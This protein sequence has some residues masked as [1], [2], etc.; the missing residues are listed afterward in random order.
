[1]RITGIIFLLA[2]AF[3]G[4]ASAGEL[5]VLSLPE[6]TSAVALSV[7]NNGENDL[8]RVTLAVNRENLPAWLSVLE[9]PQT[10]DAPKGMK[11]P[12][13]LSLTFH[14]S[15]A[16][17][18]AETRVPFT[19]KDDKGNAWSYTLKVNASSSLPTKT[20]LYENSPNPFNPTTTIRFALKETGPVTLAVYN[21]LGQKVRVL[22][23]GPRSAGAHAVMWDSRDEAG[24]SVSS[25]VYF[26]R[27]HAG[28]YEKTQKMLYAR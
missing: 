8:S 25:G 16:P 15:N 18:N 13:K 7:L 23:D 5:P 6:G 17:L 19:L 10:V 27:L 1:M 22:A 4:F 3:A 21:S 12:E 2:G 11:A 14:I 20:E 24:R 26:C 28:K 9:T